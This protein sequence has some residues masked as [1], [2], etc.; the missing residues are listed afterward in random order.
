VRDKALVELGIRLEDR[1]DGGSVWKP[2]DPAV[3]RAEQEER[4]RGAAEARGKK[5]RAQ[6]DAKRKVGGCM[7]ARGRVG[8][9]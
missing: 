6:L 3:L 7:D 8:G 4:R 1:P 2:E 5:L 9:R